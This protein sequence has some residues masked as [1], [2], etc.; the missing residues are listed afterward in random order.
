[1]TVKEMI[2]R[3]SKEPLDAEVIVSHGS[4]QY[5]RAYAAK[6][7]WAKQIGTRWELRPSKDDA[8]VKTAVVIWS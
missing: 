8:S 5:W 3:L 7:A 1:M 2:E 6:F 4:E